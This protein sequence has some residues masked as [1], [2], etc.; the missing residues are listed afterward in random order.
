VA[1]CPTTESSRA[2]KGFW[3][4]AAH[5][6]LR[7]AGAKT[8]HFPKDANPQHRA[9]SRGG[10]S[11]IP[12]YF[13]LGGLF[14]WAFHW[15]RKSCEF[16]AGNGKLRGFDEGDNSA[17]YGTRDTGIVGKNFAILQDAKRRKSYRI[18]DVAGDL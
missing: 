3:Q 7:H 15:K 14:S 6:P 12:E 16:S 2:W 4:G 1:L 18:N 8:L 13:C 5:R 11:A 10:A 9:M 17:F